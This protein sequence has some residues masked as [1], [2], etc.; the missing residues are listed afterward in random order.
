MTFNWRDGGAGRLI[1]TMPGEGGPLTKTFAPVAAEEWAA[2][3]L[4]TDQTITI[5][6]RAEDRLEIGGTTLELTAS[7]N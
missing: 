1:G 4:L 7:G 2:V 5:G 6:T 3:D